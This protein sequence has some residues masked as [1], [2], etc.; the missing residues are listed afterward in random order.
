MS[1]RM[2]VRLSA[3]MAFVAGWSG[4]MV[5]EVKSHQVKDEN[6]RGQHETEKTQ[7]VGSCRVSRLKLWSCVW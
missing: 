3:W 4:A 2:F 7:E 1:V 6:E 5:Y